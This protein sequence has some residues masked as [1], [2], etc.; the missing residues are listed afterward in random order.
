[1]H[2]TRPKISDRWRGRVWLLVECG[3]HRE[4]ECGAASGSLHR[5]VRPLVTHHAVSGATTPAANR[6]GKNTGGRSLP[7]SV[8]GEMSW[9]TCK[10]GQASNTAR[11]P[12][13]I[14]TVESAIPNTARSVRPTR[15]TWQRA[16]R[17]VKPIHV[18]SNAGEASHTRNSKAS[19]R[20]PAAVT[21]RNI[22]NRKRVMRPNEN[23]TQ[24]LRL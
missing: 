10:L 6:A 16:K 11:D 1:M 23:S 13:G 14:A 18:S 5:L 4:L 22:E 15:N 12:S 9:A 21:A 17:I 2:L 19:Y 8:G 20:E 24:L 3:S 7:P